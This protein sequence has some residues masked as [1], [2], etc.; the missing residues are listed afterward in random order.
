MPQSVCFKKSNGGKGKGKGKGEKEMK[1]N[2]MKRLIAVIVCLSLVF[3][4]GIINGSAAS[5]TAQVEATAFGLSATKGDDDTKVN[6]SWSA[7]SGASYYSVYYKRGDGS[8]EGW[9]ATKIKTTNFTSSGNDTKQS[10][11]TYTVF[12][13]NDSG[14]EIASGSV[15][16]NMPHVLTTTF[17]ITATKGVDT[18]QVKLSWSAVSGASY[19]SV[20]YKRGDGTKEGWDATKIKTT[21]FTS[22]GNDTKQKYYNFTVYAYNAS[23]KEIARGSVKYDMPTQVTGFTITATKGVDA[24]QVKLS[25]SAVSGAS[26][27]N[28]YYKRGDGTK[29]GWDASKIKTTSFTSIGNDTKQDF[30]TFTVY[31]YNASGN[32]IARGSVKYDMPN[33]ELSP[34][35][36]PNAPMYWKLPWS[37]NTQLKFTGGYGKSRYTDPGI[38]VA[39]EHFKARKGYS[40]SA[41]KYSVALDFAGDVGTPLYAP[42]SGKVTYVYDK[43]SRVST[44]PNGGYGN[45][46]II[47]TD[48][49]YIIVMGHLDTVSAVLG[50]IKQGAKIGT[51]GNSGNSRGSHLHFE[52]RNSTNSLLP[53]VSKNNDDTPLTGLFGKKVANGSS[54]S[55]WAYSRELSSD[56]HYGGI[57][58]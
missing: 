41:T 27:Y 46:V 25:W 5:Q 57:D 48:D 14:K 21:S 50:D 12:A 49:G 53:N 44:A 1:R 51:L 56:L 6:L 17:T 35:A 11:Y 34:I 30:Y 47:E 19:Y 13:Y 26:Y 38:G 9:D 10:F 33:R 43:A 7:V 16:Y 37:K 28:V 20:Y 4:V 54:A 18:T 31:A 32:E 22:T 3:T 24:T 58:K 40:E 55:Y 42:T 15:K 36:N 52:I 23:G 39:G 45:H 2:V 29:E 8:K